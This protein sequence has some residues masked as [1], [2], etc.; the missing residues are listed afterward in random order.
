MAFVAKKGRMP[1]VLIAI[2]VFSIIGL[3]LNGLGIAAVVLLWNRSVKNA[4][5]IDAI[6]ETIGESA[7]VEVAVRKNQERIDAIIGTM[8]KEARADVGIRMNEERIDAIIEILMRNARTAA[9]AT[10]RLKAT[11]G[12][13]YDFIDLCRPYFEHLKKDMQ[14]YYRERGMKLTEQELFLDIQRHFGP[15][16]EKEVCEP[17]G[18]KSNECIVAAVEIMR[19][20]EPIGGPAT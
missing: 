13:P 5:R 6:V 8:G 3:I 4:N 12:D 7:R 10:A 18:L 2:L 17:L 19:E 14:V 9:R 16:M 1:M 20:P 15:A 11:E